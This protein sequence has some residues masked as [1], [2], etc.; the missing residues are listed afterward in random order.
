MFRT[1]EDFKKDWTYESEATEKVFGHLT[2][3]SLDQ[4]VKADGR[5]LRDLAWH[6]TTTLTE[7]PAQAGYTVGGPQ[8]SQTAP[9]S[10]KEIQEAYSNAARSVV[11]VFSAQLPDEKLTDTLTMYGQE[12]W[13]YG[14]V[15]AA[16][17]GH[18]T[19]HRGQ[20]TVLMRQAGLVVPG[21]YGPAKE[22]WAAMGMEAMS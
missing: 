5:S 18:Q 12:G 10:L 19:H 14:E 21:V 16:L 6:I 8:H 20:M 3:E 4:R 7:M 15:L 9:E 22:E 11:E 17:I 13:R 2:Q 1:I